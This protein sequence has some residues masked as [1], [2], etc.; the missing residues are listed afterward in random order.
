MR[1][2]FQIE[3]RCGDDAPH[4]W[5]VLRPLADARSI[6]QRIA[7]E[8][9]GYSDDGATLWEAVLHDDGALVE[10]KFVERFRIP[11]SMR[12]RTK[13][14]KQREFRDYLKRRKEGVPS[15]QL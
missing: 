4:I 11:S 2:L 6:A 8:D 9:E 3:T 15:W 7:I 12:K 14:Q 5:T 13:K 1:D 10:W